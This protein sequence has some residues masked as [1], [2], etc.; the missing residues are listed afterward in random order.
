MANIIQDLPYFREDR[1]PLEREG[2]Y[3]QPKVKESLD[4]AKARIEAS[5]S[6]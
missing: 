6:N 4:A 5:K 2:E 1:L 3:R